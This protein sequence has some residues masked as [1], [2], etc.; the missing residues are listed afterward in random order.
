MYVRSG[1]S[2]LMR[3]ARKTNVDSCS[4]TFSS[5]TFFILYQ[6]QHQRLCSSATFKT[7]NKQK[8]WTKATF[9]MDFCPQIVC[10]PTLVVLAW[11]LLTYTARTVQKTVFNPRLFIKKGLFFQVFWN[12]MAGVCPWLRFVW[13]S[14]AIWR[15]PWRRGVFKN[16]FK[17]LIVRR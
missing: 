15:H 9:G 10:S 11:V 8:Q 13:K 2:A 17:V 5:S 4:N 16:K 1:K 3:S 7:K 14:A 12:V 6:R